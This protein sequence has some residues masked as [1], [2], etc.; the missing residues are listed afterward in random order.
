L[1]THGRHGEGEIAEI[2][3]PD[4]TLVQWGEGIANS[5]EEGAFRSVSN[6]RR[7]L[8]NAAPRA[9]RFSSP[10]AWRAGHRPRRKYITARFP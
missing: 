5:Q 10:A 1:E 6:K 2:G 7:R 8:S 9:S 4:L 3:T